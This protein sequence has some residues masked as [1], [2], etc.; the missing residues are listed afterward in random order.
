MGTES[1]LHLRGPLPTLQRQC[2]WDVGEQGRALATIGGFIAELKRRNVIRMAGLYLVAAWLV[3]QVGATLLPVF[4]APPWTMKALVMTL[5]IA[6]VPALAVAWMFELTPQGLRRDADVP[7]AESIAP[8]TARTLDRAII[9]LLAL[10]LGYFGF[11]KFVLS[12]Q[13]EAALV[14][15]TTRI[16]A[17]RAAAQPAKRGKSIAVLPLVNASGD[18]SQ[19]FFSDGLSENLITT[20]AG[21]GGLKVIGR[22]SSFQFRDSKDDART[23]GRKLGAANLISGSVQHAGDVVRIRVELIV[24]ADGSTLWSQHY[25]RPY[26]DLFALQDEIAGTIAGVLKVRLLSGSN[27]QDERPPGGKLEAYS[28]YLQARHDARLGT[29]ADLKRAIRSLET[30]TRIDPQ[31]ARAW[32]ELS[33]VWTALAATGLSG[34]EA[35]HAYAESRRV[36]DLALELAPNLAYAHI[37]RGWLLENSELDWDGAEREY[38]RALQLA[39]ELEQNK[40]SVGSMLASRG[41]L[42]EGMQLVREAIAMDPLAGTW[43]NWASAYLSAQGKLDEAEQ[44]IRKSI[45]LRPNA[46][47][48]WTQ[49][50]IIQIQRGDPKAALDAAQREPEGVWSDIAMAMAH[51]IGP[52]RALADA[53]L[54]KLI[55]DH[56]DVAPYQVAQ[57]YAL[58]NDDA[59]TFDWLER[60]RETR[61]PGVGNTMID[62]LVMRYKDDPRLAAFCAKIGLPHPRESQTKGL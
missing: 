53:A 18:A 57:V 40:F 58:R 55:V 39:P 51:Q 1:A 11:D 34:A 62:P 33:R 52:D 35:K 27:A 46:G 7:V 38:R 49:L 42:E 20:L 25:D 21:F 8:R 15:E 45:E 19:Q 28:G 3:I 59:A 36:S 4:D 17:A 37:A 31:Y 41:Q 56:G 32:A 24:V 30:A 50:T 61:D 54:K 16:A 48:A 22:T 10:A 60:A 14:A 23:I 47:S 6:F 12:P 13:R 29:E 44:A 5:A 2:R 43:W 26:K 9:V